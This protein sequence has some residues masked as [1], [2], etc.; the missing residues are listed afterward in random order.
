MGLTYANLTLFNPRKDTVKP[1]L[2]KALVDTGAMHLCIPEHI[3]VKLELEENQKREIT[4]A[5]GD[6]HNCSYVGPLELKFENRSCFVGA[7]VLGDE[8]LMG[9]IPM[10]DMDLVVSPS[11]QSITVNPESPEIPCTKVK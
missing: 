4:L 3:A 2:V 7:M 6:K 1:V 9:A 8:V 11:R 5:S 10:E